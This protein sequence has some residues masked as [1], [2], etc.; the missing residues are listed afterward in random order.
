MLPVSSLMKSAK[1]S[2]ISP[3]C[4]PGRWS[5]AKAPENARISERLCRMCCHWEVPIAMLVQ[6]IMHDR[7]CRYLARAQRLVVLLLVLMA[8]PFLAPSRVPR[9]ADEL[10]APPRRTRH[11]RPYSQPSSTPQQG[12]VAPEH[13]MTLAWQRCCLMRCPCSHPHPS[14]ASRLVELALQLPGM[15]ATQ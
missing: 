10:P 1:S 4:P 2:S 3:P 13:W 15:G 9:A 5:T 6:R 8:V 11:D 12:F 14:P 7:T